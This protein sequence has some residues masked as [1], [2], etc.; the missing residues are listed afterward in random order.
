MKLVK[1]LLIW[2][3]ALQLLNMSI[4][5]DA[6]WSY[7]SEDHFSDPSDQQ[8]DP[9]ETI[10]EWLVEMKMGQQ[11]AF[12]YNNSIDSKNTVK[13][14]SWHIDMESHVLPASISNKGRKV[15]F[16]DIQP[17]I[18]SRFLEVQSPPPDRALLFPANII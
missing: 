8:A 16:A 4:C 1:T 2:I 14:I 13:A 5:S 18:V 6:Y 10:V 7:Y 9:T 15:F 3:T 12:T 11:D 17:S